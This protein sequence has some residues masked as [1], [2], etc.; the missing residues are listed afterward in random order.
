MTTAVPVAK[1]KRWRSRLRSPVSILLLFA[2]GL[3]LAALVVVGPAL[4]RRALW[5]VIN[6]CE[7]ADRVTGHAWPCLFVSTTPEGRGIVVLQAP[8]DP[9]HILVVPTQRI[10]GL[11]SPEIDGPVGSDYLEASWRQ[12]EVVARQVG[13]TGGWADFGMAIN[14]P[15]HRT[16]KQLHVH[17]ECL[18]PRAA[19]SLAAR[20]TIPVDSWV[21]LEGFRCGTHVRRWPHPDLRGLDFRRVFFDDLPLPQDDDVS[22]VNVGAA[23]IVGPGGEREFMLLHSTR[24]S[25]ERLLDADCAILRGRPSGR[26]AGAGM[27]QAAP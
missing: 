21:P 18:T 17:V 27:P 20:R 4:K 10:N 25:L 7:L 26:P 1:T 9:G 5:A 13:A 22:H 14:G 3:A 15:W 24:M 16:Q 23:G 2:S 11:E 6:A 19:A 8:L 12:K